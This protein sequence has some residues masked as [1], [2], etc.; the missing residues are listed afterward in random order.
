MFGTNSESINL[1]I[2]AVNQICSSRA[3]A[4]LLQFILKLGNELNFGGGSGALDAHCVVGFSLSS[5][6]KLAQTKAF[7]GGGGVT[8]L[9]FAVQAVDVR[10]CL[11]INS[12][13]GGELLTPLSC[14]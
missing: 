10:C 4:Q 3:L 14:C 1:V 7:A 5:L 6:A 2:R 9:Q 8:F 11:Y 12:L 13:S